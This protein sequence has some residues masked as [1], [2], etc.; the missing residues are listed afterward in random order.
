MLSDLRIIFCVRTVIRNV[1]VRSV[2]AYCGSVVTCQGSDKI[3]T[4]LQKNPTVKS[5]RTLVSVALLYLIR[6]SSVSVLIVR[7]PIQDVLVA[8]LSSLMLPCQQI[9]PKTFPELTRSA[10]DLLRTDTERVCGLKKQSKDQSFVQSFHPQTCPW[11]TV[12]VRRSSVADP[13]QIRKSFTWSTLIP[14]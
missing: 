9:S 4:P 6:S 7:K 3:P 2:A 14:C 1:R 12:L 5:L 11:I 10:M 8:S 13:W